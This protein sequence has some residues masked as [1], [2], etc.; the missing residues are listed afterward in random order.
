MLFLPA[1]VQ[2]RDADLDLTRL[3]RSTCANVSLMWADS[4]Y[5]GRLVDAVRRRLG[6]T[7]EIVKR[8]D[9]TTGFAVHPRGR[10]VE[11]TFGWTR[12]SRRTVRDYERLTEPSEAMVRWSATTLMTRRA[13][14]PGT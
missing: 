13:V 7:I 12:N 4:G 6:L 8:S 5:A 10:V 2:D 14:R 1:N 3:L 11:R 9:D